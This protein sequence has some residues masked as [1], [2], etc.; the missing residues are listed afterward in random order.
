[1]DELKSI[2]WSLVFF[3]AAFYGSALLFLVFDLDPIVMG[4][5]IALGMVAV[6]AMAIHH[7][8]QK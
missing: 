2:Q 5:G 3:G 4:F 7:H 6:L 8:A 1:M